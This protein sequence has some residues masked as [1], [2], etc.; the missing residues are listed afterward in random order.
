MLTEHRLDDRQKTDEHWIGN[1]NQTEQRA[2]LQK[3]NLFTMSLTEMENFKL[4]NERGLAQKRRSA[5]FWM[6]KITETI[7]IKFQISV[8]HTK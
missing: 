3:R 6:S 7:M 1:S 4:N 2:K 8:F 5:L